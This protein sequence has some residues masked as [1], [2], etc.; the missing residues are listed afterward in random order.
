MRIALLILLIR[1]PCEAMR[2]ALVVVDMTVEQDWF[3]ISHFRLVLG[4]YL[5]FF[6]MTF[7]SIPSGGEH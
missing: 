2:R 1:A 3:Q 5:D 6:L 7:A 4:L